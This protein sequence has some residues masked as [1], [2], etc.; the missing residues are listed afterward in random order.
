MDISSFV[1]SFTIIK[2]LIDDLK[3]ISKDLDLSKLAPT[4]KPRSGDNNNVRGKVKLV[5][6]PEID[7]RRTVIPKKILLYQRNHRTQ[8]G[9]NKKNY[10][11]IKKHLRRI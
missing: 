4:Y 7:L 9:Q 2:G 11:H 6:S 5:S 3:Q 1:F 8:I 10:N